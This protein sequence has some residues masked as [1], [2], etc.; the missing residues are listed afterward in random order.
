M[1]A[2]VCVCESVNWLL[3]LGRLEA[4]TRIEVPVQPPACHSCPR[5]CPTTTQEVRQLEKV[6]RAPVHVH[7]AGSRRLGAW[8]VKSSRVNAQRS[9]E[10]ADQ[11]TEDQVHQFVRRK[12]NMKLKTEERACSRSRASVCVTFVGSGRLRGVAGA[13]SPGVCR[14]RADLF[15]KR[16]FHVW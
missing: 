4:R 3:I 1:K 5:R 14:F 13:R 11:V 16:R 12:L 9:I 10:V 7:S 8:R 15:V 2:F 6:C